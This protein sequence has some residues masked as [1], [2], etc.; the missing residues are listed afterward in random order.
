MKSNQFL[1]L[2]VNH[3]LEKQKETLRRW[4]GHLEIVLQN[5]DH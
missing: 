4:K 5:L 2:G 3:Q 1:Y